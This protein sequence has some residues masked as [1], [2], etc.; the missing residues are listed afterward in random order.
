MQY[1]ISA[2]KVII[3]NNASTKGEIVNVTEGS[4]ISFICD[5]GEVTPPGEQSMFN[6]DGKITP[7][8]KVSGTTLHD[9]KLL[10][11]NFLTLYL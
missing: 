1:F 8:L 6:F 4:D 5:Y 10:R 9:I 11:E 3:S 7:M 2:P